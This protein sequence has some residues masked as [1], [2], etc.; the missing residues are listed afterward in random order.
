MKGSGLEYPIRT[1][2]KW[3]HSKLDF[4]VESFTKVVKL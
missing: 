3:G 4:L 1:K 2:D